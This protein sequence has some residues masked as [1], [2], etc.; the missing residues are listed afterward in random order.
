MAED[1]EP[2]LFE[3]ARF[4]GL[5]ADH[6]DIDPLASVS[7]ADQILDTFE[8]EQ[9]LP[10]NEHLGICDTYLHETLQL[11]KD[12]AHLLR[13]VTDASL[14]NSGCDSGIELKPHRARDMKVET[15]ILTTDHESDMQAFGCPIMPDLTNEHLPLESLDEEGDEGLTWP[16]AYEELPGIYLQ[17]LWKEALEV[18]TEALIQLHAALKPD[19]LTEAYGTFEGSSS[20]HVRVR[21]PPPRL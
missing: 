17:T 8:D 12:E 13:S 6:F 14:Q 15:P 2:S 3:Y 4:Y 20:K 7:I 16:S 21:Q 1:A 19:D 10:D 9:N 5:T 11:G 18:S